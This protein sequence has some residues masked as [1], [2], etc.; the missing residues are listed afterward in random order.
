MEVFENHKDVLKAFFRDVTTKVNQKVNL[1]LRTDL[2]KD[3]ET[4]YDAYKYNN[5]LKEYYDFET[6]HNGNN[7][8]LRIMY[9]GMTFIKYLIES[10]N[11]SH[12]MTI[13]YSTLE[14]FQS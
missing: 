6:S 11:G 13:F 3:I 12:N 7:S 1:I 10:I 5:S 8:I 4:Q 2:I 14:G 9:N